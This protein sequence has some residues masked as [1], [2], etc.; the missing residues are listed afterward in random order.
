MIFFLIQKLDVDETNGNKLDES[1]TGERE[2]CGFL[3]VCIYIDVPHTVGQRVRNCKFIKN[4][5][6]NSYGEN[7]LFS[8]CNCLL[9]VEP[10]QTLGKGLKCVS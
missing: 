5:K 9:A 10:H 7:Y 6:C 1:G 8:L 3:S 2:G 4:H